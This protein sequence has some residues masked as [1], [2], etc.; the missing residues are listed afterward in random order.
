MD[1]LL[2]NPKSRRQLEAFLNQPAQ[3]LLLVAP[4]G[5]GKSTVA[6][7]LA[8][9]LLQTQEMALDSHPYLFV[10]DPPAGKQDIPIDSIRQLIKDFGLKVPSSSDA[11]I[12]RVAIID[13]SHRLSGEAQNALLKLLEEPPAFTAL[14]LN[15]TDEQRLLPT[16]ISRAQKIY[17]IPPSLKQSLSYF[18]ENR[19]EEVEVNWRLS[20]GAAGLLSSLIADEHHPL[21]LAVETAKKFLISSPY[22]RLLQLQSLTKEPQAFDDF[23]KALGLSLGALQSNSAGRSL[24][25]QRKLLAARRLVSQSLDHKSA[26]TNVKLLYLNF[27][28]NFN[29]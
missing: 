12:N 9:R 19:P 3:T 26:N 29:L 7:A 6:R 17:L 25:S 8:A 4:A 5:S 20:G 23:L 14:I 27:C 16:V 22:E 2:L 10:I 13:Q 21:R 28:L 24:S 18:Q 1:D 11:Q 15:V